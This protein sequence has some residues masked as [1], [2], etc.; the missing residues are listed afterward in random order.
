MELSEL[1]L[2][3]E[4]LTGFQP[5]LWQS[6]FYLEHFDQG[7][8]PA[9]ADI[10]TGLGKTAITALW[11]IAIRAGRKLPRRLVYVVD[12]RAVVDQAT[13]FV[14]SMRQRLPVGEQFPISTLRGKHADNREWLDDP[15]KPAIIVGTV[16]MIGSRLLF[17]GY[18]VSRKMRPYHAGFLGAD[19]LIVLDEAHLIPPFERLLE[20]IENSADSLAARDGKDR[21]LVPALHL[22]S[23]SATG[24]ERQGEVFRL[25]EEDLGEHTSLTRHRLNAVK[26]LTIIN[27]EVKNLPKYLAEAAWDLTESGMCPLR[28]LVYCNSRD[29]AKETR[30]ELTKLGRR[31]AKG[32]NNLPEMKTELFIGARRGHE[33]ESAADRLRE[34]GFL[35]GS[36]SKGDS[37]R[38]LVA[39]SAGEVGV[40]LDADHMACDLV[41]WDR[42]VQRLGRVNR[43]GDG[44]ARITVIDAGPFAPKTVSA[45]EMRRIEM[46][47]RQVRTL[48]EALPEIEDGHDA[49]PRA[50]HDLKQQAEPDLRAV[51]EQATT[52]VPLRPALTRA[53]LDAWSMTSLKMHAG[54]P[55]VAPWLRGWVDDK[56][57][58]VVLWR[59][60]LPIPAPLP[61]LEN[62]RERR[63][64]HKDIA[65]YFEATPPHVSEQL[66]TET[67]LVA[68]WLVARA[69][70]LIEQPEA[71]FKAQN[72]GRPCSNDVPF[73]EDI[74]A[75]ALNRESEFAQ[76]FTLRELFN[77][78][79]QKGASEEEKKRAKKFMDRLK[80]SLMSKTLVVRYTVGG[81][82]ETGTLKSKVSAAPAW[83]GDLDE[84]WEPEARKPDQ[85]AIQWRIVRLDSDTEPVME[86]GWRKCFQFVLTR[87]DKGEVSSRLAVYK[88]KQAAANEDD[89][90]IGKN[91]SLSGHQRQA[92]K[93]AREIGKRL[94]LPEP[95]IKILSLAASLHDEGKQTERWQR[96]FSA[97]AHDHPYAKTKGPVNVQF[98]D[99]YRHEFGSLFHAEQDAEFKVL[100]PE[101]QDLVLHMIAAHHG[102]A[103][104]TIGTRGCDRAP[105][106]ALEERARDVALRFARLQRRWGPWGLAW[107]E[108]LLRSA[109]QQASKDNERGEG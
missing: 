8:V 32:A 40:D 104:P 7:K 87:D 81:L 24:R 74:V 106:S 37:V 39:T 95:Y 11:L 45:T 26:S 76:A 38:F 101:Q 58:T 64:W 73:P 59:A 36:E 91:Q 103:R 97:P 15:S 20:S 70:D 19:T 47:H 66:E 107:W 50:I 82:D 18:G 60:H 25:A 35:A 100:N 89:R 84:R 46:A 96:A 94:N 68:D 72:D 63:D 78:V 28:C 90:A 1:K 29:Q 43:R 92:E 79:V 109:D 65:A 69:K 77:A 5:M 54:R 80:H 17:E 9:T 55:E 56:P 41:A 67:H 34:L 57:Q 12:R 61:E 75:I 31:R 4:L 88:W 3:F 105:P 14:E 13:T 33:R 30:D 93:W 51:M 48:L 23:L 21:T 99:G 22:L 102:N 6:R 53:L 62:K 108:S 85:R 98:L 49:S 27:G 71:E 10:P 83:L 52:P 2:Q 44:S 86:I 16:D 42:M